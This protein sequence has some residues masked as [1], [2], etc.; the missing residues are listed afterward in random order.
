M[1][2]LR[3]GKLTGNFQDFAR[4]GLSSLGICRENQRQREIPCPTEQGICRDR[5]G[6]FSARAGKFRDRAGNATTPR[7]KDGI[8]PI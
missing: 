1:N 6:N 7:R 2:S 4:L 5:A 3:T 8:G